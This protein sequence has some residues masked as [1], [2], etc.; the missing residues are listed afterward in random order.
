MQ[1][2]NLMPAFFELYS[3]ET[4]RVVQ[5]MELQNMEL[6]N[7]ELQ[8]M[9]LQK[10]QLQ[11]VFISYGTIALYDAYSVVKYA[12]KTFADF[13]KQYR[14][15]NQGIAIPKIRV[16]THIMK[17]LPKTLPKTFSVGGGVLQKYVFFYQE[18]QK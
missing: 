8:N 7:M 17:T 16:Y 13:R 15:V 1:A 5:K 18:G 6:Q 3:E 2:Y 12:Q 11:N 14:N 9:E 4:N 10:M